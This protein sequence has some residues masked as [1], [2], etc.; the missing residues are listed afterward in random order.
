MDIPSAYIKTG[1]G[2]Q[3]YYPYVDTIYVIDFLTITSKVMVSK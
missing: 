3:I 1:Y 2:Q